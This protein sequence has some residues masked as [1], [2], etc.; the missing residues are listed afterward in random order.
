MQMQKNTIKKLS[1][2]LLILHLPEYIITEKTKEITDD[3]HAQNNLCTSILLIQELKQNIFT[4]IVQ[5]S[6]WPFP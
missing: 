5:C 4:K 3:I 1:L 2:D 6:S